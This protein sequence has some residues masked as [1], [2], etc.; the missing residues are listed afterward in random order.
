MSRRYR[1]QPDA[2]LLTDYQELLARRDQ[3]QPEEKLMAVILEDALWCFRE[4]A[5]GGTEKQRAHLRE[6]EDWI[7]AKGNDWLYSFESI[8]LHLDI[9]CECLRGKLMAWK[10]NA[11]RDA[12]CPPAKRVRPS[13]EFLLLA[14]C[15][16]RRRTK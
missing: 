16:R 2:L 4:N 3:L 1:Q 14:G 11:L 12:P 5:L 7:A 15:P 13:R 6:V 8:C 9:N 10:A